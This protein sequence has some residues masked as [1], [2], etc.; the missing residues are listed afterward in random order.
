MKSV[1]SIVQGKD[2]EAM[3][4]EALDLIGGIESVVKKG[5]KVLIKPNIHGP[6]PLEDHITTDPRIV[7]AVAEQC[8]KAGAQEV[9]V[10]EA[11]SL[12]GGGATMFAYEVSG[13]K[14]A[15]EKSGAAKLVDLETDEYI[16]VKVPDGMILKS[17]RRPRMLMNADIVISTPIIKTHH[18]SMM[19]G[20]LKNMMGTLNREGKNLIHHVGLYESVPDIN[21]AK[22]IN[23]VVADMLTA[24]EGLGPIAGRTVNIEPDGSRYISHTVGGVLVPM[25]LIVAS[26][27]PVANDAT[28][29]RIMMLDPR[30]VL[31]IVNANKQGLGN[32]NA[33]QIVVKGK[34]IKDVARKFALCSTDLDDW[35]EY[36]TPH[37]EGACFGCL[38]S[39]YRALAILKAR[40]LLGQA[41]GLHI[42]LGPKDRIPDEWGTGKNLLLLG[43]CLVKFKHLG[44]WSEGCPPNGL[45]FMTGPS[46][47]IVDST[48]GAEYN[49]LVRQHPTKIEIE[50]NKKKK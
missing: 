19:T 35:A 5:N 22:R 12:T 7:V 39:Q 41:K 4:A 13:L 36:I 3:V 48:A 18:A 37:T 32:I 29:C 28:C 10:G 11:P 26:K 50:L 1:V 16:D 43:N 9:L 23:L 44:M 2:V 40:G 21:K 25:N 24:M 20:S 17:I 27:D 33:H 38:A 31:V 34:K 14:D 42:V 6:H 45:P 15:V 8:Q 47:R 46:V 30:K 49:K